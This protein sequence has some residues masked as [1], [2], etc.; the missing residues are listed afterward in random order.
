[1]VGTGLVTLGIALTGMAGLSNDLSA[2]NRQ[3]QPTTPML[4]P[5]DEVSE[6]AAQ[7]RANRHRH[8]DCE[9]WRRS[10]DEVTGTTRPREL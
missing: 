6:T 5:T 2:A 8:A 7:A 4:A 1:M 10:R 9:E 3:L